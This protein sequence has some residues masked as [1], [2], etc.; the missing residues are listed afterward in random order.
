MPFEWILPLAC[1]LQPT[2]DAAAVEQHEYTEHK[3]CLRSCSGS[4][5]IEIKVI[6]VQDMLLQYQQR[7]LL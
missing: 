2:Q 6:R 3:L 7:S 1:T 4:V 5:Q